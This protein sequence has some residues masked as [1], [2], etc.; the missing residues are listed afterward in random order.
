MEIVFL[1][2]FFLHI[3]FDKTGTTSIQRFISDQYLNMPNI[4]FPHLDGSF[5]PARLTE[6]SHHLFAEAFLTSIK[7]KKVVDASR[8]EGLKKT[9][10]N[11]TMQH[12]LDG[13]KAQ[14]DAADDRPAMISS[15]T[16]S[17]VTIDPE[18]VYNFIKNY[19]YEIIAVL[20]RQDGYA[21][22][23]YS[24]VIKHKA[25]VRN[26]IKVPKFENFMK[27]QGFDYHGK[28]MRW[29]DAGFEPSRIKILPFEK[30]LMPDGVIPYLF[31][32]MGLELNDID[33]SAYHTNT[34]L[35]DFEILALQWY[36]SKDNVED[37]EKRL[38]VKTAIEYSSQITGLPKGSFMS[39]EIR[40]KILDDCAESNAKIV[41]DFMPDHV[42]PL[43]SN[44]IKNE[45]ETV[46][47]P[48]RLMMRKYI[49]RLRFILKNEG[50][51]TN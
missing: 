6:F 17:R 4:L 36:L 26:E 47:E 25:R 8:L 2:K 28:I 34:S 5:S 20:R 19:D 33:F 3:G 10:P 27:P 15:E 42:G 35:G 1:R 41:R 7:R 22:S 16:F 30:H 13:F 50:L 11:L 48:N 29:V 49:R 39:A 14:L 46:I 32:S 40:K 38:L 9:H 43:F 45:Q 37:Y 12:I 31:N 44:Q 18:A 23:K 51:I 24:Q 21:K